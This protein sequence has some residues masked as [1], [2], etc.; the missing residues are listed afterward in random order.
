[1]PATRSSMRD[2]RNTF[3]ENYHPD[4]VQMELDLYSQ[5]RRCA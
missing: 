1:M 4:K 5:E 2:L 3:Y